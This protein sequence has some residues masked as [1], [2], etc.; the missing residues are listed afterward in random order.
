MYW[1]GWLCTAT[2]GAIASSLIALPFVRRWTPPLWLGWAIP[3][4]VMVIFLYLPRSFFLRRSLR[5]ED[6]SCADCPP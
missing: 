3:L 6:A 2:L 5:K 1:Y 4:I